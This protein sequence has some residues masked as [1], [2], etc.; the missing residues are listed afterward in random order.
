MAE[1]IRLHVNPEVSTLLQNLIELSPSIKWMS[2]TFCD[3]D[4]F[5][6]H[7]YTSTEELSRLI[8]SLETLKFKLL[9]AAYGDE[10]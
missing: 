9:Q 1:I 10:E 2:V 6:H 3:K 5:V 7:E 8:G 4:D